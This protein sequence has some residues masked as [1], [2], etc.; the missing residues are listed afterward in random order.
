MSTPKA[1][2]ACATRC[3]EPPA[4]VRSTATGHPPKRRASRSRTSCLWAA[5]ITLT[6][7]AAS[8]SAIASPRPLEDPQTMAVFPARPSSMTRSRGLRLAAQLRKGAAVVPLRRSAPCEP[9]ILDREHPNTPWTA[10]AGGLHGVDEP[11][12]IEF[13]VARRLPVVH[14]IDRD[15]VAH[16]RG[17]P[18]GELH[19]DQS[20]AGR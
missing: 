11:A 4:E 5:I 7:S 19:A 1:C 14:P 20:V 10:K 18:V 13:V 17:H 9:A 16:R 12:D 15:V 6:S 2:T 3:L 8:N